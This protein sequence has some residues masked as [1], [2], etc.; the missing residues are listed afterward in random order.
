MVCMVEMTE[1]EPGRGESAGKPEALREV[2]GGRTLLRLA[3]S[4]SRLRKELPGGTIEGSHA[5]LSPPSWDR[6]AP[7][8]LPI[9]PDQSRSSSWRVEKSEVHPRSP[10][11]VAGRGWFS[12]NV[13]GQKLIKPLSLLGCCGF[14]ATKN[15]CC[16]SGPQKEPMFT[17]VVAVLRVQEGGQGRAER[18]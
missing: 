3:D 11:N 5:K 15:K 9:K 13:A 14:A 2:R 17:R 16:G 4:R 1:I 8:A 6:G 10:G 7:T 18:P 12:R